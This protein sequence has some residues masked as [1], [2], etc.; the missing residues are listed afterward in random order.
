MG[1][2]TVKNGEESTGLSPPPKAAASVVFIL[3][4]PQTQCNTQMG[5]TRTIYP[6]R[7]NKNTA[8]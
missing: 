3:S 5:K 1:A 4:N 6:S 8:Q 7:P 2:A